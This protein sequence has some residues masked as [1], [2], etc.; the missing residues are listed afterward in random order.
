MEKMIKDINSWM[1]SSPFLTCCAG[2]LLCLTAAPIVPSR[3]KLCCRA[4]KEDKDLTGVLPIPLDMSLSFTWEMGF[5][6]SQTSLLL[7]PTHLTPC[8][9]LQ[10]STLCIASFNEPVPPQISLIFSCGRLYSLLALVYGSASQLPLP[11]VSKP[12]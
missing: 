5:V 10:G 1:G 6:V 8:S 4:R 12:S 3:S 7:T 11:P 2:A 9:F